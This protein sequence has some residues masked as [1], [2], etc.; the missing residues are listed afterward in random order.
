MTRFFYLAIA[1]GHPASARVRLVGFPVPHLGGCGKPV[2]MDFLIGQASMPLR[3]KSPSPAGE[4]RG[5][6]NK[7]R[8]NT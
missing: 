6:E 7:I 1:D 5:E 8:K 2:V 4:G 3:K